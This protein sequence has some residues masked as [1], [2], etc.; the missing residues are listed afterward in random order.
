MKKLASILVAAT[1]LTLPLKSV[2]AEQ[3]PERAFQASL[4]RGAEEQSSELSSEP[5]E[6]PETTWQKAKRKARGTKQWVV[7]H[8]WQ[9]L[10][11]MA[12]AA[13]VAV[14]WL[15]VKTIRQ[16]HEPERFPTEN[17]QFL[18]DFPVLQIKNTI[19]KTDEAILDEPERFP[20]DPP[21]FLEDFPE[22]Q[23]ENTTLETDEARLGEVESNA[24]LPVNQVE[25]KVQMV[26]ERV[27]SRKE[28][29]IE[30][31]EAP[32]PERE[33]EADPA[34]AVEEEADPAKA[35]EEEADPAKAVEEEAEPAKEV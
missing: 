6:E 3:Q 33:E 29:I 28:F 5:K 12:A 14:G 20:T 32:T 30:H 16:G 2:Y 27:Q 15:A 19:P 13:T 22:A 9:L 11:E 1:L 34:K 18:G 8:K 23:T 24:E 25:T 4:T 10:L 35:V 26:Q 31:V 7:D 21:P 17:P